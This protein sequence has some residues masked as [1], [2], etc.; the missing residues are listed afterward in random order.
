MDYI[1]HIEN[2]EKRIMEITQELDI[3]KSELQS[4]TNILNNEEFLKE[5][6]LFSKEIWRQAF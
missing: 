6:F 1:Q 4:I 2:I 3:L 5:E